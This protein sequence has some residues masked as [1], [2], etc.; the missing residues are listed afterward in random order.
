M[1][2]LL[3]LFACLASGTQGLPMP[4]PPIPPSIFHD[5]ATA[6]LASFSPQPSP[7]PSL[8]PL[9][10]TRALSAAA[11]AQSAPPPPALSN[12]NASLPLTNATSVPFF[13][14]PSASTSPALGIVHSV[15]L[16]PC[17][18]GEEDEPCRFREGKTVFV[19]VNYTAFL[20]SEQPRSGLQARDDAV[21]PSERYAYSGQAFDAC[22]YTPC[23]IQP[24]VPAL[25]T[26]AFHTLDTPF[27]YLTFNVTDTPDGPSL[28][29]AGF[30][31]AFVPAPVEVEPTP[32]AGENEVAEG[33]H[34][35]SETAEGA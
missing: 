6:S 8:T 34:T 13:P 10:T 11:F 5:F 25:Y 35:M 33:G 16:S 14:C 9:S 17:F 19:Q 4:T 28:F 31:A 21:E 22:A 24:D 32:S 15:S 27:S 1:L 12:L 23:P 30:G 2:A 26:Y 20:G 7:T 18:R 29:C 3:A